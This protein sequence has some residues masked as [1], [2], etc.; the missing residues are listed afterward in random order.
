MVFVPF[1]CRNTLAGF[2]A[3]F[4]R[5]REHTVVVFILFICRVFKFM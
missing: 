5:V 1:V 4:C 2:V 3:S